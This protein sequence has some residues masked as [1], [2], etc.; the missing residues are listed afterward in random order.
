MDLNFAGTS[1]DTETQYKMINDLLRTGVFDVEFTKLDGEVR[2]MPCTLSADIVP[3]AP[4]DL[5]K[6]KKEKKFDPE[7]MSVWCT[8]KQSWRSFKTMRVISVTANFDQLKHW[9]VT[10]DEDVGTGDLIL[11]L[12]EQL[13]ELQGWCEGDTLNWIDNGDGT[14]CIQ[15]DNSGN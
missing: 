10:L 1:F 4:A 9:T 11:P 15:K 7:T 2:V 5:S 3:S 14:W 6:S 13:L 12:P 8:D